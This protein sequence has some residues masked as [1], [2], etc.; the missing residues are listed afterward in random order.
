M[1]LQNRIEEL[2]RRHAKLDEKIHE[3]QKRPA[4]DVHIIKD[5]KR[6]KLRLKEEMLL[7]RA[8]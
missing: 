7:L 6:Q 1:S 8:S 3:E 2:S 5:L 4:A